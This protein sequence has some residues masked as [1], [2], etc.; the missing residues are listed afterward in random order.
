MQNGMDTKWQ[1]EQ[2]KKELKFSNAVCRKETQKN[3]LVEF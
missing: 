1:K 2:N 3:S